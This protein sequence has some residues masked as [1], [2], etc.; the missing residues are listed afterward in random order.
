[1][2]IP[3]R[4][5]NDTCAKSFRVQDAAAGKTGKCPACGARIVIPS[6]GPAEAPTPGPVAPIASASARTGPRS[7]A[8][9]TAATPLGPSSHART[10]TAPAAA[11]I[12]FEAIG[13]AW[14]LFR[15][16]IGVWI[17]AVLIVTIGSAAVHFALFLLSISMSIVGGVFLPG[18]L[19]PFTALGSLAV[20]MGVWGVFLGG[21]Y[22][23][24]LKQIDGHP[25]GLKDLVS[26]TDIL[27]SLALAASLAGLAAFA[28]FV[29]L[30]IP[31]WTISGMLMFTLPLVVDARLK[32]VD[33]ISTSWKTLKDQWLLAT[34]FALV[35]WTLQ[36]VGMMFCGLG[37]IVTFPLSILSQAILYRGFFP[38]GD[39][40]AKPA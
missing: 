31:G 17:L 4:C 7:A 1:M 18:G 20:S 25:I 34:V 28:G 37:S 12:R 26:G 27:P 13:E 10:S 38:G 6:P 30:V 29:C 36:I 19:S 39:A 24:A 23:M 9:L 16:E 22:R 2:P 14:G 11:V 40:P 15:Q 3:V 35:L 5:P 32:A 33:A 8:V 21:M